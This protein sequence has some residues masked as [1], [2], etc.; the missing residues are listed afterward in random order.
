M[1]LNWRGYSR[2]SGLLTRERDARFLKNWIAWPCSNF[3]AR[4]LRLAKAGDRASAHQLCVTMRT[5]TGSRITTNSV[6]KM[7]TI[8]GTVSLAGSA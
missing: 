8:I 1:T 2:L 6:G 5:M 4:L 3:S 7:Q